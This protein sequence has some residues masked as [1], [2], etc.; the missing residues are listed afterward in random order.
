MEDG[1]GAVL[2]LLGAP[3][4]LDDAAAVVAFD[5]ALT[6]FEVGWLVG[7]LVV[8]VVGVVVVSVSLLARL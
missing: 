4:D 1:D 7:W 5:G 3:G 8:G 2:G 6:H